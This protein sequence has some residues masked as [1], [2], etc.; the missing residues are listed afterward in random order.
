MCTGSAT[1]SVCQCP[2]YVELTAIELRAR[3]GKANLSKI[4]MESVIVWIAKQ[5]FPPPTK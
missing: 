1:I 5:N 3:E 4:Q 2:L